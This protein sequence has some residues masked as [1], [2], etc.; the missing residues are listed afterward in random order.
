MTDSAAVGA[1][2]AEF[3]KAIRPTSTMRAGVRF[4]DP[5]LLVEIEADAYVASTPVPS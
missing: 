2:H 5:A 3:F 4:I 1:V